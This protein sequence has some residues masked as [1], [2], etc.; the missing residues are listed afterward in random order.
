MPY[1]MYDRS[2]FILKFTEQRDKIDCKPILYV[3]RSYHI[4]NTYN[5][6]INIAN[7]SSRL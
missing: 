7:N 2:E 4:L 3:I 5:P 6:S 1:R